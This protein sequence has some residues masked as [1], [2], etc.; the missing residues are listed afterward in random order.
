M[1]SLATHEALDGRHGSGADSTIGRVVKCLEDLILG[2]VLV[3]LLSPI[4]VILAIVIKIDSPGPVFFRQTR[5]GK[6]LRPFAC[7]K[8]RTMF[9]EYTDH[10]CND[11]TQSG[12]PRVTRVGAFLRHHSLDELP[13]L[14]NVLLGH[15][16]LC[17][18]RPHAP[19]T[20]VDNRLLEDVNSDYLRRYRVKPGI[21]GWAQTNGWR[22]ILDTPERLAKR[23]EFDLYYIKHWSVWLDIRILALTI[24]CLYDDEGAY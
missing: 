16:S 15:M 7:L 11:Q 6:G 10:D 22:G 18:P 23:V 19:G 3:L 4:L 5:R 12:D 17:G 20:K 13:Q 14:F 9:V 1:D 24:F 2:G 8:F 21:T